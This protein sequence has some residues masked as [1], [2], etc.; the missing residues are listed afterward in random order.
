LACG[1]PAVT[2]NAGSSSEVVGPGGRIVPPRDP[3]ALADAINDLLVDAE[4]RRRLGQAGREWVL[5]RFDQSRMIQD[6]LAVY[7][8]FARQFRPRA[9]QPVSIA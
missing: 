4:L 5:S 7:D 9:G 6:N 1:T 8:R 3:F 2:T